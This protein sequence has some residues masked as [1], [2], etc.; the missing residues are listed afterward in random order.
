ME[1][2]AVLLELPDCL[3]VSVR[4]EHDQTR[5]VAGGFP[6]DTEHVISTRSPVYMGEGKPVIV[7]LGGGSET[8]LW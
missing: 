8:E 4:P 1:S 5:D 3:L 7:G 6:P 2:V